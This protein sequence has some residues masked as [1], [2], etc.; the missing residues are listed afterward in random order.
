MTIDQAG[1]M[2]GAIGGLILG[3]ACSINFA[4]RGQ[5]TGMSGAVF[6]I[7]SLDKSMILLT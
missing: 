6:G 2:H 3:V 7:V 5:V 4:V 1:I